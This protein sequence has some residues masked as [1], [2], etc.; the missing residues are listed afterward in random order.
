M[1]IS[2][3]DRASGAVM[4]AL[5]GDAL[6]VGPHWYYD[7][8]EM[9]RDYGDWIADY[10][11][12]R[13]DRYHAGLKAGQLSQPG[14]I[15]TMLLRSVIENGDYV[16]SDFCR[17]LDEELFPRLDGT[18][19]NGPGGYTSQ[20]IREAWQHRVEERKSW[21]ETGGH[22][23]TTEAAERALVLAARYAK[24]PSKVAKTV[25]SNCILTQVDEAI[26]AMTTA[27]CCVLALLVRGES[28]DSTLS[29]KLMD[30]VDDGTLPF[31]AVTS[32]K[33]SPPKQGRE[34]SRAG[35]FSSPDALLTPSYMAEAALDPG[36]K[37]EPAWKVSIVYG[38]PCAIYHQLPI[39]YYLAA[40]FHDDFEKAVLY[41]LN[42][43]GQNQARCILTGALVGAQVGFSG[44]PQR[45]LEGLENA[46]E[47]TS[48]AR[49]LG[50]HAER[51]V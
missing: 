20:S 37:I 3:A 23:D 50:D 6:G 46:A 29:D 4:G 18:P 8:D 12:P 11:E 22:A 49:T 32:G 19:M 39:S 21:K 45:F 15:L 43:G 41:A 51:P 36:I 34:P 48:L 27:Y 25:S 17:R 31:H 9:R 33:M 28:L 1:S 42:G 38:M 30:L 7:L 10:T 24:V 2:I 44:I 35:R 5:I 47:L 16:E 40:R 26:V 13:P 14:I